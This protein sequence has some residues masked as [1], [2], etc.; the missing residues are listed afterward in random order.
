[1]L[2]LRVACRRLTD[3][4]C[5]SWTL[6][7]KLRPVGCGESRQIRDMRSCGAVFLYDH[8]TPVVGLCLCSAEFFPA[9]F[10]FGAHV[11]RMF[12]GLQ[13]WNR[14]RALCLRV[15]KVAIAALQRFLQSSLTLHI[16]RYPSPRGLKPQTCSPS[17]PFSLLRPWPSRRSLLTVVSCRTRL[18]ERPTRDGSRT[19][20]M[21]ITEALG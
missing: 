10:A 13:I 3:I 2:F 8:A 5:Y 11:V 16:V 19:T 7:L 9:D 4:V 14:R 21:S 20:G 15:Q 6:L 12:L 18:R 17:P 1:M